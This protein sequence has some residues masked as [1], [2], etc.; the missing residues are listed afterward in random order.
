MLSRLSHYT[1]NFNEAIKLY[2]VLVE[3]LNTTSQVKY[4]AL[5]LKAG[6]LRK[7]GKIAD[8]DYL[9]A[10]IFNNC[11]ERRFLA[12][13]SLNVSFNDSLL[14]ASLK[15]CKN[16]DEKTALLMLS[17][18]QGN[19]SSF[20]AMQQ[21]YQLSPKSP[22]LELLL[23]REVNR[24][25][26][27]ELPDRDYYNK[28]YKN[29]LQE[30]EYINKGLNRK[31]TEF[32]KNI[33]NNKN[34]LHPYIWYLAAGY[35]MTLNNENHEAPTY[36]YYARDNWP[37]ND[38]LNIKNIKLFEVI[39]DIL[40]IKDAAEIEQYLLKDLIWLKNNNEGAFLFARQKLA[41]L[42]VKQGDMLRMHLL[43]GDNDFNYNLT[44]S[45]KEEPIGLL[46]RFLEKPAKTEYE[47]FLENIYKYNVKELYDI[48]G[49]IYLR[50]HNFK[51]A[52][53]AFDHGY[54]DNVLQ[55]DPFV[56]HI[57]DCIDCDIRDKTPK[58]YTK[59]SFALKMLE[60][61]SLIKSDK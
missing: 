18:F 5:S 35:L 36:Y 8:A 60:L 4:W 38:S 32:V 50:Q 31:L 58:D 7:L 12:S 30:N 20:D 47:K 9:F 29:Y 49:T 14:N 45:P 53:E 40:E 11:P 61:D 26:R 28:N 34:A 13:N 23:S 59:K 16:N 48:K 27:E 43:L 51:K 44:S 15:L 3:K 52:F 39:N 46:I 25:E 54:G 21:I 10:V 55:A 41:R 42:H 2:D 57:K 1:N 56:I 19:T 33:A 37:K 17:E 6:A 22:Y 24:V